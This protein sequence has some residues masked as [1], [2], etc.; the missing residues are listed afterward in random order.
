MKKILSVAFMAML[1][2]STFAQSK[3]DTLVVTTT[4]QMHCE[5]CENK[6]KKNIRFVKG[7]K[8][9]ETSVP[10][11]E[12]T[13]VYDGKKAKYDDFATAFKKIG[14]EIKEIDK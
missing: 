9:I 8:K 4:P 6:I 10:R 1:S 2:F 12:V 5:G 11:Q 14:Y 3:S 13:I 7:C